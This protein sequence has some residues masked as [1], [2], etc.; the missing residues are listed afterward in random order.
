MTQNELLT[1]ASKWG[2]PPAALVELFDYEPTPTPTPL[3]GMSEAAVQQRV[4]LAASK[5][6]ARLWRNNVGACL[7]QHGNMVRYGLANKSAQ[8]NRH[9]KS[10]D[11]IGITPV[12][13]LPNMVGGVLGVFTAIKCKNGSWKWKGDEH[14]Q[15]QDRF[16]KL[17]QSL[18]G[19]A[20][21]ENGSEL[22][23]K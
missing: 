6:G 13:V 23:N 16:L 20:R 21:F 22:A 8:Q 15:A 11:L 5:D 10:S 4:E 1:W 9:I 19:I 12:R 2:I 14:E 18:G 7:D 17:V 3:S